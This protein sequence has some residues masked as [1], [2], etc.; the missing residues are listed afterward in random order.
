M[1]LTLGLTFILFLLAMLKMFFYNHRGTY[2]VLAS[3]NIKS[4]IYA[5]IFEKIKKIDI[6]STDY[7]DIGYLTNNIT[8]DIT[9]IYS[10][11]VTCQQIVTAPIMIITFTIILIV[12][13][14]A[15]S[16]AG[17]VMI[18]LLFASTIGIG[19]IIAKATQDKLKLSSLRNKETTFAIT[20]MKSI[21]FNCWE[22]VIFDKISSLKKKE[23]KSIFILNGLS[24]LS[25]GLNNVI[26]TI[27]GFI[28]IVLYNT[29]EDD[30]L[31]LGRTFFILASFN[32]LISPLRFFY[33]AISG[34]E[35]VKVSLNRIQNLLNLPESDNNMQD[36]NLQKGEVIFSDCTSCYKERDFHEKVVSLLKK[37]E[38]KSSESKIEDTPSIS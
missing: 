36:Y 16:L 17:I 29:I 32:T 6:R 19:K 15:Y 25:E 24:S 34:L 5:M 38:I 7:V 31:S 26:P 13:V 21:K 28:T 30:K 27:S 37:N 12:E 22:N 14:G 9:R 3:I 23:S 20:G 8:S 35:Q 4:A 2:N 1:S 33:Y 11:V 10:F 18:I